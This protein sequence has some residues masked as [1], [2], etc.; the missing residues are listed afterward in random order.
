[1]A[2]ADVVIFAIIFA[3][4]VVVA[5]V[6]VVVVVSSHALIRMFNLA[7]FI[8][9]SKWLALASKRLSLRGRLGPF[10][11]WFKP[12]FVRI[13]PVLEDVGLFRSAASNALLN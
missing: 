8:T 9:S 11:G 13:L 1:M 4:V 7:L 3:V 2:V 5:V 10:R 12:T 6:F